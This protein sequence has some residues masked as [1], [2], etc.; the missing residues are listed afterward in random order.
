MKRLMPKCTPEFRKKSK[1]NMM[2]LADNAG[3][4]CT[5][6]G[7]C[8]YCTPAG[9]CG[10][11]E[12]STKWEKKLFKQFDQLGQLEDEAEERE[13]GCAFCGNAPDEGCYG[14]TATTTGES[15]IE[16]GY[17]MPLYVNYCPKCG[18]KMV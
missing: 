9:Y 12:I 5:P 1:C 14:V 3:E 8:G 16:T 13:K 10:Y 4:D 17:D 6:V 7:Y 2:E 11:Y 15:I 18:R